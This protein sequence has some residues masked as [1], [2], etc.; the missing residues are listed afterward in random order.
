MAAWSQNA[1][2]GDYTMLALQNDTLVTIS[3]QTRPTVRAGQPVDSGID[4]V[5]LGA[6]SFATLSTDSWM[7][8]QTP[9][10]NRGSDELRLVLNWTQRLESLLQ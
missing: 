3:I 8:V 4:D 1:T 7:I 5:A 9:D 2:E 6:V 10:T